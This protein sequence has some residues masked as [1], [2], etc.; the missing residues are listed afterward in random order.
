M[1]EDLLLA[2]CRFPKLVACARAFV[3][4]AEEAYEG[5]INPSK[6]RY[7][8]YCGVVR[9]TQRGVQKGVGDGELDASHPSLRRLVSFLR[10]LAGEVPKSA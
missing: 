8:A 2:A 7:D 10:E 1:L 6:A 9:P 3:E 4:C 5:G